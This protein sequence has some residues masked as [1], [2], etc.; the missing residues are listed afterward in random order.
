MRE[1]P[2][3]CPQYGSDHRPVEVLLSGQISSVTRVSTGH[4][5]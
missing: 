4:S 2:E 1:F 3:L 5:H